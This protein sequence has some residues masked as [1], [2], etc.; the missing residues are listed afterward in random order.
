LLNIGVDTWCINLQN[1]GGKHEC[2]HYTVEN[3]WDFQVKNGILWELIIKLYW[4]GVLAYN[5]IFVDPVENNEVNECDGVQNWHSR[6]VC[7]YC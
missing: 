1:F 2:C 3:H 7:H 6:G 5:K 4:V